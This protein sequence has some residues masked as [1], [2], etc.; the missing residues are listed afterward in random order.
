MR[1]SAGH[2]PGQNRAFVKTPRPIS[3]NRPEA[4]QV[5]APLPAVAKHYTSPMTDR[6]TC[7]SFFFTHSAQI[8]DSQQD[9]LARTGLLFPFLAS[10]AH[11][12]GFQIAP[13]M[14]PVVH[15][16]GRLS[17]PDFSF[18]SSTSITAPVLASICTSMTLCSGLTIS[19]S[20]TSL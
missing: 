13:W 4:F 11:V 15:D 18:S 7:S 2:L 10:G 20:Q 17:R 5:G 19:T 3:I 1:P 6:H 16:L 14:L 9:K 12:P 8:S